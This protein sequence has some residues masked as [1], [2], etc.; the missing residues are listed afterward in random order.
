MTGRSGNGGDE[1]PHPQ[2]LLSIDDLNR[3]F[4]D[5]Y[6]RDYF[7]SALMLC[8]SGFNG[9]REA[10]ASMKMAG[11]KFGDNEGVLRIEFTPDDE[12]AK[13]I[14]AAARLQL[15]ALYYHALET[16]T[17]LFLAHGPGVACPWMQLIRDEGP[18]FT[19][20]ARKLAAIEPT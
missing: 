18:S 2:P 17:R 5:G 6:P 15:A 12:E 19:R 1:E 20:Q 10:V 14:S 9:P 8:L 3:Q 13:A 16:L 11:V 7:E 4:Y